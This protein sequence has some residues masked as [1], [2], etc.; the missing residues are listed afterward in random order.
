[1][2][3]PRY[4][5]LAG[6]LLSQSDA[7]ELNATPPEAR[8]AAIAAAA[9]AI[10]GRQRRRRAKQW[11]FAAAAVVLGGIAGRIAFER[12]ATRVAESHAAPAHPVVAVVGHPVGGGA[13][14]VGAGAPA[15]LS[16]GR[17]L[18][19]GDRVVAQA[20]GRAV[21]SFS[22]GSELTVEDGG[23][24]SIVDDTADQV[25]SLGAGAVRA[26]VAKLGAHER[27]VIRTRDSEIE[28]RGTSFR[29]A[30]VDADP[31]CGRGAVTRVDV[32][33]GVVSV[34]HSGDEARVVAGESWPN[35]CVAKDETVVQRSEKAP[36]R[37]TQ[38][39]GAAAAPPSSASLPAP[40]S[41][42]GE[43]NDFFASA[44]A[45]KRRGA[46]QEAADLFETFVARYPSS[47]LVESALA[48]RMKLL[49]SV[50]PAKAKRAAEAYLARYPNGFARADAESIEMRTP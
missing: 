27:F 46:A 3:A 7:N 17:A 13:T 43:Q 29:V 33:E 40:A 21:L 37:P 18:A 15:P 20:N 1:M 49:R 28:V 11:A 38:T 32:F 35:G 44:L 9:K 34:R 5:S 16:E 31:N 6:K 23:D 19:A 47:S 48:Q 50:D 39:R 14:F 30:V 36:S 10:R 4:A 45:A 41:D 26:R 2:T 8:E 24:L 25:F 42:L 22:T 12:A